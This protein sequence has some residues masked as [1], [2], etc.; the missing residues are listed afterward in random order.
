MNFVIDL[1][2]FIHEIGVH[3]MAYIARLLKNEQGNIDSQKFKVITKFR[4]IYFNANLEITAKF[5]NHETLE[6]YGMFLGCTERNTFEQL[7]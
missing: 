2:I 4:K 3:R 7:T 6:L 5:W 1:E